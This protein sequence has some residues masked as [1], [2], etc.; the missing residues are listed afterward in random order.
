MESLAI[1][2]MNK[3]FW[4]GKKVL[5]T[6]HTGFK[7]GWLTI[8]LQKLGAEVIGYSLEPPTKP[9]LYEAANIS[10]DMRSVHGDVRDLSHFSK[11]LQECLPDIVIHMAA[12]SLVRPSYE[13][14]VETYSSNVMGTV[15][16]LEAVRTQND[17]SVNAVLV[18]TTDKC[19]EN[20]EWLW[21]YRESERMGGKD[22]YSNSKG[23][24]EL[25]TSS[26]RDSFFNVDKYSEHGVAVASARAGNVVGGGDWAQ[27]RLIPDII[28]AISSGESVKIRNPHSIRPWQHVLEPLSGY[29]LLI[30]KLYDD[31]RA[32]SEGWNFGPDD[33]NV[34][35]V[36][37]IVKSLTTLWGGGAG[38]SVDEGA[39]VHEANYLK[40]DCSKARSLLGFTS[41]L[42]LFDALEW[43]VEWYKEY[44]SNNDMH[45]FT[46]GQI[47]KYERL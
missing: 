31:P 5:L 30:E 25:V 40:L 46:M 23:C 14:P 21:G 20:R 7:G 19:Y 32:F 47:E 45:A 2:A 43:I 11:V 3:E 29:M 10:K 22:P 26:Y 13:N 8:W 36:Y 27:D 38:W 4:I 39:H 12:Q 15:N 18:V 1:I 37:S 24:A 34:K 16:V 42:E 35:D 6:G 28:K 33:T 17:R 9:S 44:G 41:K